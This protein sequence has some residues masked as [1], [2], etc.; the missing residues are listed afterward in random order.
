[1]LG[2]LA[3]EAF[4]PLVVRDLSRS[5][6]CSFTPPL[7][8]P[9]AH[10]APR[11]KIALLGAQRRFLRAKRKASPSA[12]A[13]PT[14]FNSYPSDDH[15]SV[16]KAPKCQSGTQTQIQLASCGVGFPLSSTRFAP[17]HSMGKGE[18][19]VQSQPTNKYRSAQ[20]SL[21]RQASLS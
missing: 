6:S 3:E 18:T 16:L 7:G 15:E 4:Q 1:M 5:E 17:F 13:L 19:T 9:Q 2:A 14:I 12:K 11:L 21:H 10:L 8:G 20:A